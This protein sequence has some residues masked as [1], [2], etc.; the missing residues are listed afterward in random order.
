MRTRPFFRKELTMPLDTVQFTANAHTT[1]GRDG[2]S[3]RAAGGLDVT[4][5][6]PGTPG[7]G[8][9]PAMPQA[10][11]ATRVLFPQRRMR[12]STVPGRIAAASP[13]GPS[14][15]TRCSTTSR[16]TG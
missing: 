16:S 4:L 14:R 6:S 11:T 10:L 12:T 7:T 3:H 8:T 9:N 5:A 2:A 13:S 1:G 15:A